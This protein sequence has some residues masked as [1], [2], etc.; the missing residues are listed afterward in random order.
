M[1]DL[2]IVIGNDWQGLYRNGVLFNEDHRISITAVLDALGGKE[3]TRSYIYL[4][5]A[6]ED[7]I[8][9]LGELPEDLEDLIHVK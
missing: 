8:D 9:A 7:L 5:H 1:V 4:N 3:H 6:Q 2:V